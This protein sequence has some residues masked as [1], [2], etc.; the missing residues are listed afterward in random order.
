MNYIEVE[1]GGKKRGF[2]FG[3]GF[4][5]DILEYFNTDVV[6]FVRLTES[7]PFKAVP[8]IL[9]FAHR[10]TVRKNGGAV[11]FELIDVDGWIEELENSYANEKVDTILG[12]LIES[13]K[14][15]I[16]GLAEIS[17]EPKKK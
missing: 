13:M 4:L 12:V 10:Y 6:G 11:D 1:I 8:A 9:Y 7:N 16:P 14:K 2:T 15:H 17:E 5:G 3:L